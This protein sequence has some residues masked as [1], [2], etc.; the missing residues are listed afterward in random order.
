MIPKERAPALTLISVGISLWEISRDRGEANEDPELLEFTP[1][2]P[3]SPAVLIRE[4]TNER[5]H[6]GWNRR[7]T[8]SGL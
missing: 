6:L 5:P 7:P 8:R 2:L 3:G 1:H 4:S